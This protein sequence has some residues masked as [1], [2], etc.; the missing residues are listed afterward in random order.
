MLLPH[1]LL[2]PDFHLPTIVTVLRGMGVASGML[3]VS[4]KLLWPVRKCADPKLEFLLYH[5][6]VG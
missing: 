5:V 6:A 2:H 4:S 1:Q 3:T